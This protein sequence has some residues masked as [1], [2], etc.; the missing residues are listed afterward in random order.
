MEIITN[1]IALGKNHWVEILAVLG[2]VDI[3]LGVV[4]KLTPVKWD[5]NVYTML[6][7]W[8]SKLVKK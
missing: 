1:L 5:D 6:H 2:A 7:N 8:I 3:I 4:T